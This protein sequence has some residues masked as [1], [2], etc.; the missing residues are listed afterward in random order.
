MKVIRTG[1]LTNENDFLTVARY[2]LCVI[3]T[4]DN[5]PLSCARAGW[6]PCRQNDDSGLRININRRMQ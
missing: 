3:R 2:L 6:N 1:L 4:E 5:L